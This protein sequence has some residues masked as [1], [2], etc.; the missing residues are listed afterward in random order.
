MTPK[1]T[2]NTLR[3][4]F[5]DVPSS[6]ILFDSVEQVLA[7]VPDFNVS[8]YDQPFRDK[9]HFETSA[10][11]D[12]IYNV[13]TTP[14]FFSTRPVFFELQAILTSAPDNPKMTLNTKR[15]K[16]PPYAC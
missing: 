16:V 7:R 9:S 13:T 10:P 2:F 6:N 1:L 3:S 14:E 5:D 12:P 11:N 15:S 4:N 8:L